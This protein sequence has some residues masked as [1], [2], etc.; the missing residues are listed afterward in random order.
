MKGVTRFGKKG[1]LAPHYIRSFL[2][3]KRISKVAYRLELPK[4]MKVIHPI[5]HVSL[6]RKTNTDRSKACIQREGSG[7]SGSASQKIA[8]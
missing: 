4:T 6:L 5:F 2:I 1:K 7:N 3:S 8:F